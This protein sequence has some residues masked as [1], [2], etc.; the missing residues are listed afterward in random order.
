MIY[1][2][3]RSTNL[4]L[5]QENIVV[6]S[7]GQAKICDFGCARM[8]TASHTMALL[9]SNNKGT[10]HFWAPELLRVPQREEEKVKQSRESDVW[11][12]G[13]T[14]FVSVLIIGN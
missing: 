11:A 14:V 2:F 5:H 13:M 1:H 3:H 6:S 4:K 10:V 7:N 12:F 9:S 8:M